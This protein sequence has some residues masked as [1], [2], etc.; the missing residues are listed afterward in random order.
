MYFV[1]TPGLL[2]CCWCCIDPGF[3]SALLQQ[4]GVM[5]Q[6]ISGRAAFA[7]RKTLQRQVPNAFWHFNIS[8]QVSAYGCLLSPNWLTIRLTSSGQVVHHCVCTRLPHGLLERGGQALR[9][10][11][12]K[13][14]AHRCGKCQ[15]QPLN[16]LSILVLHHWSCQGLNAT[17]GLSTQP[18]GQE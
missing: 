4:H 18:G 11:S 13:L 8:H 17:W 10:L 2:W 15:E 7:W 3:S 9:D 6:L 16:K 12:C 1:T 5:H 14:A